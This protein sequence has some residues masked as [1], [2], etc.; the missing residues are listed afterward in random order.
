M[1]I[2]GCK[3]NA[4]AC[5]FARKVGCAIL[6]GVI[7]CDQSQCHFAKTPEQAEAAKK[8]AYARLAAMDVDT[9]RYYSE[10][11]YNG[12]MPWNESEEEKDE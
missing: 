10:K 8:E 4:P 11:Y 7:D 12:R 5:K 6:R 1:K 9:Q 3:A 2:M